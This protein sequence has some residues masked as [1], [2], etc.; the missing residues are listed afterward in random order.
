MHFYGG[1]KVILSIDRH[2]LYFDALDKYSLGFLIE[3]VD[4]VVTL[5]CM[6][7]LKVDKVHGFN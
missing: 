2:I 3:W 6:M 4:Y 1:L 7:I 5:M